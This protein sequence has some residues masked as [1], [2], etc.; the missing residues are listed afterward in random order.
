[1]CWCTDR[2]VEYTCSRV[3]FVPTSPPFCILDVTGDLQVAGEGHSWH[4]R[5]L[6]SFECVWLGIAIMWNMQ[7][8]TIFLIVT[9]ILIG[10]FWIWIAFLTYLWIQMYWKF[11]PICRTTVGLF[12]IFRR[13]FNEYVY[14]PDTHIHSHTAQLH[15]CYFVTV[16][17]YKIS[18]LS[19][20]KRNTSRTFPLDQVMKE[21]ASTSTS[22]WRTRNSNTIARFGIF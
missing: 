18:Q 15:R 12:K 7:S 13:I 20:G 1:M 11:K 8:F 5:V 4:K 14:I 2:L 3:S 16:F 22:G 21:Q 19:H 10:S 17:G 6:Y 9:L